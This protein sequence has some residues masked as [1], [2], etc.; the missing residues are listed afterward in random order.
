M[1]CV[2]LTFSCQTVPLVGKRC[3]SISFLLDGLWAFCL[4]WNSC[5]DPPGGITSGRRQTLETKAPGFPNCL[6]RLLHKKEWKTAS[7]GTLA[8]WGSLWGHLSVYSNQS[9]LRWGSPAGPLASL[10]LRQPPTSVLLGVSVVL[11]PLSAVFFVLL[12]K[13]LR[14]QVEWRSVV[15]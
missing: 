9:Y 3:P 2:I 5:L 7:F 15:G 4:S 12:L 8:C 10:T 13:F 6:L 11:R 1:K 14:T